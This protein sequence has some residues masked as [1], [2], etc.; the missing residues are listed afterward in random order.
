MNLLTPQTVY[1]VH[2]ANE[3]VNDMNNEKFWCVFNPE[4]SAPKYV[5]ISE[6][7]A[8]NQA[9]RLA[10]LNPEQRF[11]VMESIGMAI[12]NDVSYYVNRPQEYCNDDEIPF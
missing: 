6:Q 5:H 8:K 9:K 10:R 1:N 2:H 11:Y 12:K 4:Q 3:R 7:S